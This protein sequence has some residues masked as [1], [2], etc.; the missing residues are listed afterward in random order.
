VQ[1]ERDLQFAGVLA[2]AGGVLV[3]S[4]VLDDEEADTEYD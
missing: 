3:D 1:L 4:G 2:G